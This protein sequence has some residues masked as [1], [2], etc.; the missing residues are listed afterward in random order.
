MTSDRFARIETLYHAAR[1]RPPEARAAFLKDACAGDEDLRREIE[2]LLDEHAATGR[3][4]APPSASAPA[5]IGA[6]DLTGRR[7]GG[8]DLVAAIGAG[9]MGEVYRARDTT[10]GRDVAIKILPAAFTSD[11]DR[12]ARFEARGAPACRAEPSKRRD[13]SRDRRRRRGPW[14]RAGTR[15]R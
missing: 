9:G 1:Q 14:D 6:V 4:L 13:D 3:F 10:L 8:Y 7:I 5:T 12:L 11:R 15:G 2:S